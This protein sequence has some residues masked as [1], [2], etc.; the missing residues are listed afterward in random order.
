MSCTAPHTEPTVSTETCLLEWWATHAG[1]HS[2][3]ASIATPA[4]SAT[5]ERLFSL[6]FH[7]VQKK[8][9]SLSS[10]NV[11]GLVYLSSGLGAEE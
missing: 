6:A 2:S 4:T 1:S 3:L 5:S 8:R 10:E 9:V 7:T 11:N